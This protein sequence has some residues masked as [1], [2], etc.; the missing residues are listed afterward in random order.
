[1]IY[2]NILLIVIIFTAAGVCFYYIFKKLYKNIIRTQLD[3]MVKDSIASYRQM[4]N[5]ESE[6]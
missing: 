2:V 4:P 3:N 6:V 5:T 1:L